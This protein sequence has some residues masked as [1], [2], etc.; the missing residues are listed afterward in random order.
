MPAAP[1]RVELGV[2]IVYE[3]HDLLVV[4][5]PHGLVVHPA[6]RHPDGT[7]WD[8]L[9]PLFAAREIDARPRLLHRLDR[10]TSGLLCVPK[11]IAAHRFLERALQAGRF[12]KGYL[13]MVDG[14]PPDVGTIDAPLGRAAEDRRRVVVRADGKP[15]R[16]HYRTLRRLPGHALLRVR[17]ETG[18]THQIRA[19]L[20]HIGHPLAGDPLYNP[21]STV[22]PRLFLH[23]DRLGLP[24]PDGRRMI[25]C[26]SPLPPELRLT[27]CRLG[28]CIG[29]TAG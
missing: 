4:D 22:A 23:A 16:T 20:L 10:D 11:R 21:G 3:D 14:W 17:L 9:T 27:L 19:H 24:H 6:Y 26:R 29:R 15:A 1:G 5:K 7:L 25:R 13:A 28:A 2:V 8:L 12:E 18:R